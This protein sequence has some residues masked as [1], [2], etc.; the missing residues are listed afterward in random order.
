MVNQ[1]DEMETGLMWGSNNVGYSNSNRRQNE[2]GSGS[3][4]YTRQL[5]PKVPR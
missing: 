4:G 2:M 5:A 3:G 1:M